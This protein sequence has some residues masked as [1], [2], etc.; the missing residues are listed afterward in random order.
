[1]TDLTDLGASALARMIAA[2]E[3]SAAEVMQAH[4]DRIGAVNGQVNA[5]VSLGDPDTLMAEARAAD[6]APRKGWLHGLPLAVKDLQLTAG[7]RSTMGSPIFAD[8]VPE[9]DGML[10]HRLRAE[11]AILIGK[12]NVP[13]YGLGSQSSN[14]VFGAT[15]T[16]Y[17]LSRTSGGSSGGAASALAARML[18]VADGSDMMGSLRNPAAFCNV[19]GMRPSYGLVPKDP[20]GD[21]FLH[22]LSTDGPMARNVEDLA[23]LLETLA[24]PDPR[25]PH[26]RAWEPFAEDLDR[27]PRGLRIGWLGD[28]GGAFPM[29]PGIL[30]T[31]RSALEIMADLGCIVEEVAPP[32]DASALW[33]SWITLRSW[34][35]ATNLSVH[36]ADPRR[37]DLLKP[38]AVWETERGLALS[39]MEVHRASV[40]RSAWFSRAAELFGSYD[41]LVLPTAQIWPFDKNVLWPKAIGAAEM[42]TYHRWMEVVVPAS[43]IGLPA[44]SVPAGFGTD[45]PGA[46]LPMGMQLIGPRGADRA[47]LRLAQ[48]WHHATDWPAVRPPAL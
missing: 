12:T 36:H 41:V 1:M 14:P 5:I 29:E 43:L 19:Y 28:W 10:S 17:D 9:K 27:D 8:H 31:C 4:L 38:E 16:P 32:F 20:E 42:D 2:G 39:A 40:T 23:R 30:E 24:R 44:I 3:T 47:L 37:R 13:E 48:A 7:I 11:G 45:G 22:Q 21:S 18:P 25:L 15:A 6:Q 26:G 33:Q 35:V 46:G 34:A